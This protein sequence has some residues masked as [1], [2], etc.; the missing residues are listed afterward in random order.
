MLFLSVIQTSLKASLCTRKFSYFID[1]QLRFFNLCKK[2]RE[3]GMMKV[4]VNWN[5]ID[6]ANCMKRKIYLRNRISVIA[7]IAPRLVWFLSK[8]LF[9][10]FFLFFFQGNVAIPFSRAL[11]VVI[12]SFRFQRW[13]QV[14]YQSLSHSQV[15]CTTERVRNKKVLDCL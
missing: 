9:L 5:S 4:Y 2:Q 1:V 6:F 15:L 3:I 13:S 12:D 8:I 10:K 7:K 11:E 14:C